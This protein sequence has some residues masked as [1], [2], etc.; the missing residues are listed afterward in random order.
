MSSIDT[1]IAEIRHRATVRVTVA[2]GPANSFAE[3]VDDRSRSAAVGPYTAENLVGL[4]ERLVALGAAE[5]RICSDPVQHAE[6]W[7]VR[8]AAFDSVL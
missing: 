2:I 4:A 1:L 3:A 8:A 6:Q 5:L 7:R